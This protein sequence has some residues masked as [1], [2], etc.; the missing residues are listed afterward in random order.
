MDPGDWTNPFPYGSWLYF[1][2]EINHYKIIDPGFL[3]VQKIV[4]A[5][6]LNAQLSLGWQFVAQLNAGNVVIQYSLD[7]SNVVSGEDLE[8]RLKP[9]GIKVTQREAPPAT[10]QVRA[11]QTP[12]P[13]Y[14]KFSWR[15]FEF[16]GQTICYQVPIPSTHTQ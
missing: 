11:M 13:V 4:N 1:W 3:Q 8:A 2:A 16:R 5:T 12:T 10:A 6:E 14:K 9:L 15:C 7:L